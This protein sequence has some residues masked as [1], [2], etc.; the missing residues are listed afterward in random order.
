MN[1]TTLCRKAFDWI[2]SKDEDGKII[3]DGQ[4]T[5]AA[6]MIAKFVQNL[7]NTN[8]LSEHEQF[9]AD[10]LPSETR[11][12]KQ[13]GIT[14]REVIEKYHSVKSEGATYYLKGHAM[15]AMVDYH[16]MMTEVKDK[17]RPKINYPIGGY[18][19]GNYTCTCDTCGEQ[20]IGHKRC[21]QCEPCSIK[22]MQED[23]IRMIKEIIKLKKIIEAI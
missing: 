12:T 21:R 17:T 5:K 9:M 8:V 14:T 13:A 10:F 2:E 11:P 22:K 20:F 7:I 19:P 15:R 3:K 4:I 18:A 16:K 6:T 23:N 1:K